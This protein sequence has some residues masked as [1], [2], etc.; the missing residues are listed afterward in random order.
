[1]AQGL[2]SYTK[3]QMIWLKLK[4][5]LHLIVFSW[6]MF[7]TGIAQW[8]RLFFQK[9]SLLIVVTPLLIVI[10]AGWLT[11]T[12]QGLNQAPT[13]DST[14]VGTTPEHQA[15][16]GEINQFLADVGGGDGVSF[17][18]IDQDSSEYA[19][20]ATAYQEWVENKPAGWQVLINAA[21]LAASQDRVEEAT[22]L[23][24]QAKQAWQLGNTSR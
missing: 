18:T 6:R 15:L 9:Q 5:A 19:S 1:M 21:I 10:G 7:L 14:I 8:W 23:L 3:G 22:T 11:Q 4:L 24:G 20:A 13:L 12:N 16:V 2:T 17:Q